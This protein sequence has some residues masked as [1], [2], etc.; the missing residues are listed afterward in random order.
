MTS[1]RRGEST[2]PSFL[3]GITVEKLINKIK[4]L[5][6]LIIFFISPFIMFSKT[7]RQRPRPTPSTVFPGVGPLKISKPSRQTSDL[8]HHGVVL[9]WIVLVQNRGFVLCSVLLQH[10]MQQPKGLRA[11]GLKL[12]QKIGT[13]LRMVGLYQNKFPNVTNCSSKDENQSV[14]VVTV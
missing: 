10:N 6:L 2:I 8:L 11:T 9:C 14:Y 7:P 3:G 4:S 12:P 1:G 13:R 5:S